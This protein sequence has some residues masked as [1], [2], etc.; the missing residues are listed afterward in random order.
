MTDLD[1]VQK[2]TYAERERLALMQEECAEVIQACSKILRHG[3]E[4]KNP[5]IKDSLTNREHL[6]KELGHI[7]NITGLMFD[8]DIGFDNVIDHM[9]KKRSEINKWLHFNEFRTT[10]KNKENKK[11]S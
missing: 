1:G 8:N 11:T 7:Y 5:L 10:I 9:L 6:E 2:L 4:S 3:W